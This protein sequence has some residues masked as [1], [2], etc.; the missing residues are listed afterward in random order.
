MT[1]T[2]WMYFDPKGLGLTLSLSTTLLALVLSIAHHAL[3]GRLAGMRHA[4]LGVLLASSGL[5]LNMLQAWL[6]PT[7]GM[8]TA[9]LM[10]MGGLALLLGGAMQL[11]GSPPPW[12]AL[13]ASCLAGVCI[14]MWF[15]VAFPDARWRIGLLSLLMA[16]MALKLAHTAWGEARAPYQAGMRLLALFGVVFACLMLARSLLAAAG[17]VESSVSFTPVNAGSVLAGGMALIGCVVGLMLVLSGD[18]M[19]LVDHQREHDPLSGLLN[20][21][22]LRQWIDRQPPHQPLALGMVDLDHLKQINDHHGHALGDQV[23][24]HVAGLLRGAESAVCRTARLG[25]EEFVVVALGQD[26]A[27]RLH[28]ALE[29]LR[30]QFRQGGPLPGATLS[31]GMALG[32][33]GTFENTLRQADD[34]L[35]RAKQAGRDRVD[36]AALSG[37]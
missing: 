2:L 25:G 21:L 22:G 5:A 18:L 20:R 29:R 15:G 31:A 8:A 36:A 11:R 23:I 30:E 16:G 1:D 13:A 17:K 27:G 3:G 12:R 26:Q 35:Y 28:Q 37:A 14:T 7:V 9:V 19:A 33:V 4:A 32:T 10:I 34:A 6:P 24:Q